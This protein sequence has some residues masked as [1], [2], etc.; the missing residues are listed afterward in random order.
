MKQYLKE[1][2][3]TWTVKTPQMAGEFLFGWKYDENSLKLL[4]QMKEGNHE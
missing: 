3:S 2:L 4:I 1:D